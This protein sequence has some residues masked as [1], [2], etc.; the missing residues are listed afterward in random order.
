MPE[1]ILTTGGNQ[2][3]RPITD[4]ALANTGNGKI[5]YVDYTNGDNGRSG[6]SPA[7]SVKTLTYAISLATANNGDVIFLLPGHAETL[8]TAGAIAI[9][10]AG[11]TIIG[12]GTGALRPTFTFSG[13][14]ATMTFTAANVVMEN[15]IIKP[16]IDS[17][18]SALVV[19]AANVTL[20]YESQ[21]ASATVE[22]VNTLLT[23]AAAD[24]LIVKMKHL[25]FIAGNAGVNA[26]RLVGCN[27]AKLSVDYYG[28][29]STAIVEF[30]TTACSNV[31]VT[32]TMYNESAATTKNVV[33]TQGAS[34]WS[35]D[36]YDAKAGAKLSGG[37]AGA[38]AADDV[39]AIAAAVAVI[40]EFH[41]VPAADNVLNAQMNEVLGNKEDT[42]ATGAVTTTDTLV[43][44]I[45]Q[46][47]SAAIANAIQVSK[48]DGL[49]IAT[50]PVANSLAAFLASGGTA[51]G[52]ELADSKSIIDA[53]GFNGSAFVAGGLGMYLPRCVEKTDG[54][55][56]LGDDAIFTIT[57][58]PVMAKI[59]G[60]V[61]TII[62]G[63]ANGKLTIDTTEPAATA[64]L[65][66]GAVAID[67]DAAGTSYANVGN[68]SVF[69]P[70]TAG[71]LIVGSA[72]AA[73]VTESEFLLPIGTV[74]FN[75]SAAQTGN[76]KWYMTYWP[77]SPN[78]V[79]TA[80]A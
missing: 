15:F 25:G 26:I 52:T 73:E 51:L 11:L 4:F 33:D 14:A 38:I 10:K 53:L 19:S 67:S 69:T 42:E 5:F 8:A 64:E 49:S 68:T 23:T 62:G 3:T 9:S 75:S 28:I 45:K 2:A 18:V 74:N 80:A 1:R 54:A 50:A 60:I 65:N 43:A 48:L 57:G 58:G 79:V 35:C 77:L 13:T 71:A 61:T 55:V 56:L 66:A 7:T 63:A 44:Y 34:T 59:K 32:G 31:V 46:L 72:V 36:I 39:G 29:A 16:S 41:D 27:N 70:T 24:N 12:M 47:V 6:R 78:S 37:S 40:D 21:D 76:I 17:V 22:F 20:D 30:H